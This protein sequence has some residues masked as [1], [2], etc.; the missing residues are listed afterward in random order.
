[1]R[2]Q[3]RPHLGDTGQIGVNFGERVQAACKRGRL[4]P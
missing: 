4:S 2:G 3:A 1:M